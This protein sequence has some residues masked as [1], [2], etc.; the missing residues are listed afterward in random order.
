MAQTGIGY[1]HEDI[2]KVLIEHTAVLSG[3]NQ[4]DLRVSFSEWK[5]QISAIVLHKDRMIEIGIK[6]ITPET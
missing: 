6:K 3:E 4:F 5:G 2:A 1:D